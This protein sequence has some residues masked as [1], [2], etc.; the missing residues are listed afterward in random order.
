MI[1]TWESTRE[2]IDAWVEEINYIYGVE[3]KASLVGD[4]SNLRH[5]YLD[6]GKG[7]YRTLIYY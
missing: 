4:A 5:V 7:Q 2:I 3:A 6:L 1:L